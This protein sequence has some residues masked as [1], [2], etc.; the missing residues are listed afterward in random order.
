MRRREGIRLA[1]IALIAA[2]A[3]WIVWPANPGIHFSLGNRDVDLDFR[4]VEGL[5]LQGGLQV[6]LQADTAPGQPVDREAMEAAR[7]IIEQRVNEFGTTEP[8]IQLQG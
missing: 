8:V 7:A 6:L 4:V 1:L 5:D 3:G 2:V